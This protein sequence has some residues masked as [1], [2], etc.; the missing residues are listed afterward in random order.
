MNVI[1]FLF[2][3]FIDVTLETAFETNEHKGFFV[4]FLFHVSAHIK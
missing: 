4:L 3:F 2:S 1:F